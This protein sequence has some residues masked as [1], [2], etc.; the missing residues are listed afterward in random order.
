M[1]T[2]LQKTLI[3]TNSMVKNLIKIQDSYVNTYHPD[4]MGGANSI[5]NVFDVNNYKKQQLDLAS[6]KREDSGGF[7]EIGDKDYKD[8]PPMN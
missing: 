2:L 3:P 4:F 5:T 7:E 8:S 6:L 1:Y